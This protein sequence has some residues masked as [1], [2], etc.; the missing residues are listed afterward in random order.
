VLSN[1]AGDHRVLVLAAM[2]LSAPE[3]FVVFTL[4]DLSLYVEV[5]VLLML[6][7][8][9]L[10]VRTAYSRILRPIARLRAGIET[11]FRR[12]CGRSRAHH[13]RRHQIPPLSEDDHLAWATA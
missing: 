13:S 5:G 4:G 10:H 2:A 12:L 9:V 8:T 3:F 7:R 11:L 6:T 1:C